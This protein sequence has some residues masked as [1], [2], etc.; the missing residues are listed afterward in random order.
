MPE[1]EFLV[2]PDEATDPAAID[3]ALAWQPPPGELRRYPGL[4]AIF[5]L[6]AGVDQLLR[7]ADPPPGVPVVRLVDPALTEL[8]VEYVVHWVIHHHR[9]FARYAAW[10]RERVWRRAWPGQASETGVGIMG[11]GV[12]GA[13]A[14]RALANLGFAVA[15]WSRTPRE[16]PGV[17]VF[18]GPAQLRPFLARTRI[19]VCLLPLTPDTAD[20]LRADTLAA[21]P[22]GA[23]LINA[24]RG[25][26]LVEEDLLAAL[27]AGRIAAATLDVFRTEPL[28]ADHP[29]WRHPRVTVTPHV[30]SL[31]NTFTATGEIAAS[32]RRLQDGLPLRHVAD[33]E[34]GY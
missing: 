31:T 14:A 21:L 29:F 1:L 6:G 10:Q 28:P 13:A 12:L 9:G 26:H 24:A 8:M 17:E 16:L 32:I 22:E 11:L 33:P 2:W 34:R 27:D 20:I 7:G 18:A 5:S 19:L 4:R 30:A 15:G 3:Y 23:C 25:E